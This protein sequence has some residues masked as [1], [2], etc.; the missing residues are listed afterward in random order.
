MDGRLWNRLYREIQR[1]GKVL[2]KRSRPRM[3]RPREYATQEILK[4]WVFAAWTDLPISQAHWQLRQTPTS[5]WLR[6]CGM[7]APALASVSTLTRRA[8]SGDFRWLIRYVLRRLRRPLSLHPTPH[9]V[10]D[11]TLMLTGA[12][13]RDA[14]SRWTCHGGKWF[15]GYALHTICDRN[16]TLW[17]WH[18][19]SAN[20]QEL[21]AARR[22]VRQLAAAG[23]EGIALVIGDTGYDSEPLHQLVGH[24]LQAQ[25][26]A[27]VNLRGAKTDDWRQRQ[28]G[29]AAADRLLQ[30][31]QGIRWLD[32]RSVVERWNSWFKGTSR[33]GMLP[34]HVRTLRRVRLWI[35]LK[36]MVFF[37]HQ[38]LRRKDLTPAA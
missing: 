24:R 1:A 26:L 19:T 37:V 6:T 23:G 8:R 5:W 28:L 9:V 29:R 15:R 4:V 12:Y 32:E 22:L 21:K 20:V 18:V 14:E 38:Y 13:S 31:V 36:L 11:G 35:N 3:G 34:Y 30:T 10:I 2:V 17:A 7:F 27:P 25:L 16:G 33:I